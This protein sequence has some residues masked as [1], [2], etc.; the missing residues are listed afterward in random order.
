MPWGE[1]GK[2]YSGKWEEEG[3]MGNS[4]KA[5]LTGGF[6]EDCTRTQNPP[7]IPPAST[8]AS[9]FRN[10]QIRMAHSESYYSAGILHLIFYTF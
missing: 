2:K 10:S 6:R 7:Q 8:L 1:E 9:I 4:I 5:Y 3:D